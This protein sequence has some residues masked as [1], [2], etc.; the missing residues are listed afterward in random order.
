MVDN[1]AGTNKSGKNNKRH[2]RKMMSAIILIPLTIIIAAF[3]GL[4][5]FYGIMY[6]QAKRQTVVLPSYVGKDFAIAKEELTKLGF[7]VEATQED[8]KVIKM[9]PP[10]NTVVKVG[11]TVKLFT[12]GSVEKSIKL[13]EF[14]GAWY[15]SVQTVLREIGVSSVV[16]SSDGIGI[17]GVV[18]STAPTAGN[19]VSSGDVVTLFISRGNAVQAVPS[20]VDSTNSSL[21]VIPPAI[22]VESGTSSVDLFPTTDVSPDMAPEVVT[23]EIEIGDSASS[24][25]MAPVTNEDVTIQD[26]SDNQENS[27]TTLQ[28]GQF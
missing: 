11:R 22:E 17:E 16:K 23:P 2:G 4:L 15:R 5:V 7:K 25:D 21:E 8:G 14:K 10:G 18:V 28:G 26:N 19:T 24:S 20:S 1:R 3:T 9:D 27:D 12:E 6:A 13:P